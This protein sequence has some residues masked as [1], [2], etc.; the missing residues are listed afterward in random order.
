MLTDLEDLHIL[1]RSVDEKGR[2]AAQDSSYGAQM[3]AFGPEK[4]RFAAQGSLYGALLGGL[5][6]PN[7][8]LRG[9]YINSQRIQFNILYKIYLYL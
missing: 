5:R 4:G 6:P 2:F 3:G 8:P 9:P 7:G 1:P